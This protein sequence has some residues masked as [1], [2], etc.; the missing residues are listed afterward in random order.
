MPI[1]IGHPVLFYYPKHRPEEWPTLGKWLHKW[2]HELV[3]HCWYAVI[4]TL[5]FLL[6]F[7]QNVVYSKYLV[8][9][10]RLNVMRKAD[11]PE[12]NADA[13]TSDS[14]S[15]DEGHVLGAKL[16]AEPRRL[17]ATRTPDQKWNSN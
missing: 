16:S 13:K 2:E 9:R 4:D 15:T 12:L 10:T 3:E 7:S 1:P 8:L 5:F 6:S 11:N 17:H 14:F